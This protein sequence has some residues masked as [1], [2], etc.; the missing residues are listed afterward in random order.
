MHPEK[1]TSIF[2]SRAVS[3]TSVDPGHPPKSAIDHRGLT[4]RTSGP[5]GFPQVTQLL[6][7]GIPSSRGA[8]APR[9]ASLRSAPPKAPLRSAPPKRKSAPKSGI[10]SATPL[11]FLPITRFPFGLTPAQVLGR[12]LKR[13]K[14]ALEEAGEKGVKSAC[15]PGKAPKE[16]QKL[17]PEQAGPA[18]HISPGEV[19]GKTPSQIDKRA[20]E[21][22]LEGR[23]PDPAGG[24]GSY[25]DPKTGEQRIRV[26]PNANPPHGHVNDPQGHPVG[27]DGSNVSRRSLDA[28]LPIQQ[29]NK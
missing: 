29:D 16:G 18:G 11:S 25:I 8:L 14:N 24:R 7:F 15:G 20:G 19:M 2:R 17:L 12:L 5:K 28:H 23:G 10:S 6:P 21:L 27:P 4:R 26:E 1:T 22:G 9:N 13:G 3:T